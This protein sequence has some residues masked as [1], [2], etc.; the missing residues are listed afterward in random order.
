M[1][2]G[3]ARRM[4]ATE[5]L[6]LHLGQGFA[7]QRRAWG[8]AQEHFGQVAQHLEACLEGFC[9]FGDDHR[10]IGRQGMRIDGCHEDGVRHRIDRRHLAERTRAQ[11]GP[12]AGLLQVLAHLFAAQA[13][14]LFGRV[15]REGDFVIA[16]EVDD[17]RL[18]HALFTAVHCTDDASTGRRVVNAFG[19]LVGKKDLPQL[20]PITDLHSH[21]GLHGRIVEADDGD[22]AYGPSGLDTLRRRADYGQV[23]PSFYIDHR[24][25]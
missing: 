13:F 15:A 12:Q 10:R 6:D 21:G 9:L 1:G 18:Q 8:L 14:Q 22:A 25:A 5:D 23:K 19:L 20:D 11:C 17:H 7:G 4:R 3:Q 2:T 16:L 24:F